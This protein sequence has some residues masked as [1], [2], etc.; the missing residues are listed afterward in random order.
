MNI[1]NKTLRT[2][3]R[4]IHLVVGGLIGAYLYSPL[5][6]MEW[7]AMLVKVTVLPVL[8]TSGLMMWQMPTITKWLKRQP[9]SAQQSI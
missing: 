2:I 5:G 1:S 3:L 9:V 4:S 8:L 7:F 6:Q